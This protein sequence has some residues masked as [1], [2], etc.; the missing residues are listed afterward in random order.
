MRSLRKALFIPALAL[1]LL[2]AAV[3]HSD[4]QTAAGKIY[5]VDAVMESAGPGKPADFS[6]KEGDKTISLSQLAKNKV[7]F[8]NFW[9]TW[10]GPCRKEIPDIIELTKKYPET[11]F[12]VLGVS[13]DREADALN[14]VGK[15]VRLKNMPYTVVLGNDKLAEAYGGIGAIPSTFIIA[16]DG[17]VSEKIVGARTHDEFVAAVERAMKKKK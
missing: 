6:W 15:F 10:C 17:T 5:T 4:A 1:G 12:V 13:M 11:E 16:P 9:A 3:Q 7:V 14:T 2:L 8:L